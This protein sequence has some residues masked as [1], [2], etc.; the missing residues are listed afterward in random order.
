MQSS[1]F[2]IK[3][4]MF[5]NVF[6]FEPKIIPKSFSHV[7]SVPS[8]ENQGSGFRSLLMSLFIVAQYKSRIELCKL[9]R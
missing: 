9:Y 2:P 3:Y 6:D 1:L 5:L 7:I 4:K 8:P